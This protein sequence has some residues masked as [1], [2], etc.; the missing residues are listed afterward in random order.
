MAKL[1]RQMSIAVMAAFAIGD[2]TISGT[3][4]TPS[5]PFFGQL[6]AR[7]YRSPPPSPSLHHSSSIAAGGNPNRIAVAIFW[8]QAL[9]TP[10]ACFG[11]VGSFLPK[12]AIRHLP[13]Y[14]PPRVH[15]DPAARI[16]QVYTNPTRPIDSIRYFQPIFIS[17][18]S[19]LRLLLIF[20]DS[21]H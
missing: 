16:N 15:V 11:L 10:F 6:A 17:V 18:L 14:L 9:T 4:S 5:R 12:S 13:I 8:R 1:L 7:H 20:Q 19:I 3:V 21:L 2:S